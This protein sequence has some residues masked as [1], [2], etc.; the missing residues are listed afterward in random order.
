MGTVTD[1]IDGTIKNLLNQNGPLYKERITICRDCKLIKEDTI[2]GEVCN[3]AL[4]VNPDTDEVSK[5]PKP[6]FLNGCG[7][8][9]K[10]KCRVAEAKCPLN[11][12]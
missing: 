6:G 1:I 2:F 8:I 12:W 7:C 4:Y 9:L 3:A 10:S 11:R 5:T